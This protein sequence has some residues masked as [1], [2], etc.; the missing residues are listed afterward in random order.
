MRFAAPNPSRSAA[1]AGL[2]LLATLAGAA[3]A[4][5]LTLFA[6]KD[7]TLYQHVQGLVSNGKGDYLFTGR[8]NN[9]ALIRRTVI[10]FD[11]SAIPPGSEIQ[12]ATL[13]FLVTRGT[14]SPQVQ[15]HRLT[16]DWVEGQRNAGVQEGEGAAAVADDVTWIHT[17]YPDEFWNTPGGDFVAA[18]SAT[19][20]AGGLESTMSFAS[21]GLRADVRRWVD[22]PAENYGWLLRATNES[23]RTAKRYASRTN[24]DFVDFL[25][26][27]DLTFIPALFG[28]GFETGDTGDWSFVVP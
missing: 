17:S 7:S 23:S 18:I 10:A 28:D 9:T 19:A 11:L 27:L 6:A 2:L 4:E 22:N 3:Q 21:A 1:F 14:G 20:T 15:V 5:T 13:S 12:D 16:T 8:T 25:P 24:P 26:R